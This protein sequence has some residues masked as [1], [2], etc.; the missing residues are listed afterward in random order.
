[1][2]AAVLSGCTGSVGM[3]GEESKQPTDTFYTRQFAMSIYGYQPERAL[4]IID[5]ALIVGNITETQAEQCRARI[6]SFTPMHDQM[7][8]LLGGSKDIRL[9]SA[10]AIAERINQNVRRILKLRKEMKR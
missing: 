7:D 4:Q 1:M 2:L 9:D 5:S 6:Y 3:K 8:S 10:Q